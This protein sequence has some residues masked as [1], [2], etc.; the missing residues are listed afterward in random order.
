MPCA[1][2]LFLHWWLFG[3]YL[4]MPVIKIT[5]QSVEALPPVSCTTFY[6]DSDLKGFGLR[7]SPPSKRAGDNG[8]KTWIVEYRAGGGGRGAIKRR[9]TL[10]PLSVLDAVKARRRAKDILAEVRLGADPAA[11]LSEARKADT[12]SVW[13]DRYR[14]EAGLSRKPATKV[15]YDGY[16]RNW[17]EP[18]LGTKKARD[19]TRSDWARVHRIIGE[20]HPSTANRCSVLFAHFYK[21]LAMEGAVPEGYNPTKGVER[22]REGTRERFLT[23]KELQR[24]GEALREAETI[25]I[26]WEDKPGKARSKHAPRLAE[27]RMIV[28]SPHAAAAIRLLLFTGARLREILHLRWSEVDLERGLL[29]LPDSKTGRK[30]IILGSP[31]LQVIAELDNVGEY[32]IAGKDSKTP[33]WDLQR[34]WALVCRRAG[35][36]GVRL[37]DL[38][39]TFA[40]YGAA[41]G[42][43]LPIIGGLLGHSDV[44]TTQ[45]YAHIGSD[46]LRRASDAI[47]KQIAAAL[48][49]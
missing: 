13:A 29:L 46:P 23:S 24:L 26:P 19:V 34:P 14:K 30:T 40:S 48:G 38:R 10:G 8:S 17:I 9:M 28:L 7:V 3:G 18:E 11:D 36:E 49:I 37:H 42:L 4:D 41:G 39:H 15:L 5:A 6:F 25:G 1:I 32:V 47:S 12:V 35:L 43:G 45:R 20:K 27:N 16:W 2:R 31:A 22:Y 44:K 21:W 33:R